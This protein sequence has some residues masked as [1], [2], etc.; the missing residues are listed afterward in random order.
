MEAKKLKNS[1]WVIKIQRGEEIVQTL[2]DFCQKKEISGGFFFGLGAVDQIKLAHY[3]VAKKKYQSLKF[4]QPLEMVN[5]TGSIGK[6]KDLII[7]AHA[8]FSDRKMETLAGHLVLG[9]V[10]GTAEIYLIGLPPL[11]KK[12]DPE[13]GLKLFLLKN[14]KK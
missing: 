14:Q 3:D 13:T 11:E 10:S 4:D 1:T 2:K 9:K 12:Y 5:L 7:H 6:E 8:V